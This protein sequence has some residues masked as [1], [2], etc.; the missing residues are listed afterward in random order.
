MIMETIEVT[1][2]GQTTR[3]DLKPCY[4]CRKLPTAENAKQAL[5]HYVR[6]SKRCAVCNGLPLIYPQYGLYHS[7]DMNC[8][9]KILSEGYILCGSDAFK[10]P[11]WDPAWI[12]TYCTGPAGTVDAAFH[13]ACFVKVAPGATIH[14]R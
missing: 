11:T 2:E 3:V 1:H 6:T 8:D 14:P 13:R 12:T 10:D 7:V 9:G 4:R 5:E